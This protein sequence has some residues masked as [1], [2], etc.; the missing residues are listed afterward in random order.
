MKIYSIEDIE[1]LFLNEG[2]ISYS[3]EG[4][5]QLEHALQCGQLAE[6]SGANAELITAAFL[7]DIGHLLNRK[8]ET[9]TARGIDDQ[10]QFVASHHLKAL[11][12]QNVVAPI[13]LHVLGKRALC[14]MEPS[15]YGVL[16]P[17][18]KRS[19]AL[20]G[21]ALNASE[22]EE[23]LAMPFAD[24]AIMVRRWDDLAKTI[25]KATPTLQHFIDIAQSVCVNSS[26]SNQYFF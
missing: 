18:S 17:D 16:S 21:G 12:N 11:F 24:D 4:I 1:K 26:T 2:N 7:H 9:P 14:A 13:H 22:L 20:Q 3:G 5:N 8:G 19:L 25:G 6:Q 10:H 23:F 15:Y